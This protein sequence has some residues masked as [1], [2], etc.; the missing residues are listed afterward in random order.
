[1]RLLTPI[2][3]VAAVAAAPLVLWYL[4]RPRRRRVVVGSTFLWRSVDR[5]ATA[6]TPWQRFRGDATFWLV[7][8]ALLAL[9]LAL[10]RPAVPVPVALGDHTILVVDNSGSMLADEG[11]TS[12]AE[13]AR[14][15]ATEMTASLAPGQEVSV[16]E[17]GARARIVLSGSHDAREVARA[18]TGITPRHAPADLSDAFTLATSLQRP[19]QRTVVH[20]VTD[21]MVPADAAAVAPPGLTVSAVGSDR[22]NV[23]ITRLT[24]APLGSG[25]HQVLTQVRSFAQ[26][27]V[28]GRLVLEV[29]DVPV[30]EQALRLAPRTT[31]DVVV[32]V[33]AVAGDRGARLTA[34]LVLAEDVTGAVPDVLHFDDSATTV[35]AEN[36]DLAVLLAGPGNTFL[37]AALASVPGLTV[38]ST[39]AVPDDLTAVDLLVV[40]RVAAP[41]RLSVPSLLV[42]PT[43]WPDGIVATET[44][45]LP[46][47]TYQST[48]HALLADVDLTGLAVAQTAVVDAPSLT[49]LAASPDAPLLLAGRVGDAP[50]VVVPFDLL[51]SDLP[52]RPAWPLMVAN[53]ARW[54]TGGGAGT[55]AVPVGSLVALQAPVGTTGMVAHAPHGSAPGGSS[56]GREVHID[57]GAPTLLVDEV[58]TWEV[59]FVGVEG[60]LGDPL[61]LPVIASLEE[62]DLSRPRPEPGTPAAGGEPQLGEGL[63]TLAW[64]LVLVALVLLLLE[65]GWSQGGRQWWSRARQTR[66][67]R[68][69][70]AL[71]ERP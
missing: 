64:P 14:R 65:W 33:P 44:A 59:V 58:G 38:E 28:N 3:L 8:L 68:V 36:R 25:E 39:T 7:L 24:S 40:D 51:A 9:A 1:M 31:E 20:L 69:R 11:G 60:R 26:T 29:D 57:P 41:A 45:D 43:S 16:I 5:P 30:L 27:A 15:E 66:R 37:E 22:P 54:L 47:L 2:G 35:L 70:D 13:L 56:R 62:G 21:A 12:R 67:D 34:R 55:G 4:L 48:G 61:V 71:G 52:L 49:A 53:T 32:T 19:G 23:A 18:L 50:T 6:A 17:A 46:S 42:A 10:A 63:R